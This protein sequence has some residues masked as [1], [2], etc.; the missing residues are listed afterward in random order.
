MFEVQG[1]GLRLGLGLS[2][3]FAVDWLVLGQGAGSVKD[4][5]AGC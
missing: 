5:I 4:L 2:L 1:L 3:S